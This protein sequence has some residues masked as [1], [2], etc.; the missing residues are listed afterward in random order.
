MKSETCASLRITNEKK[1]TITSSSNKQ[2]QQQIP[3]HHIYILLCR[4]LK[5]FYTC[6][7]R[8]TS[9]YKAGE[10]ERDV[11]VYDVR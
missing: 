1:T 8:R 2:R 10:L 6:R 3:N 7:D 9:T 4:A 11:C 5:N